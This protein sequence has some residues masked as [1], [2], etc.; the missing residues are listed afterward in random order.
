MS[1]SAR[2]RLWYLLPP[3]ACMAVFWRVPF[4]WFQG[5]DFAWLGLWQRADS[6]AGLTEALFRPYAQGTVR[7]FSERL[8]FLVLGGVFGTWA[9]PFRA[10][11]LG[12]WFLSLLLIQAIGARL[13]GSRAAGV[14][15]ALLWTVSAPLAEPLDWASAYNQ[16][17]CALLVLLAFYSRLR[18]KESGETK[19]RWREAAAYLAGFGALEIVVMYPVVALLEAAASRPAESRPQAEAPYPA[20]RSTLWMFL[21]A[22]LFTVAHLLWIP[23]AP[24]PAYQLAIDGRLP[25]TLLQYIA[26]TVGPGSASSL[27]GLDAVRAAITWT[28]GGS[29]AA[30]LAWRLLRGDRA[31]LLCA[32]WFLLFLAPVL[33]LPNHVSA[34]YLTVPGIGL[35]WLAGWA[36]VSAAR[37]QPGP[38]RAWFAAA[39]LIAGGYVAG[40]IRAV[41][42]ITALHLRASSRMRILVRAVEQTA[43]THPESRTVVLR[44]VDAELYKTGFEDDPFRL[45]GFRQTYLAPD[46]NQELSGLPLAPRLRATPERLL[47]ML[48][49][50]EARVL[51]ISPDPVRDITGVYHKVLA[52]GFL[53]A[54][55]RE[56]DL[57]NPVYAPRLGPGWYG[58]EHGGRWSAKSAWVTLGGPASAAELLRVSGLAPPQVPLGLAVRA[59]G[60]RIGAATLVDAGKPFE[61]A[62]P[63]PR[64]LVGTYAVAVTLECS[65][66]FRAPGDARELGVLVY[67]FVV[68]RAD[69][70]AVR[71]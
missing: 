1:A 63:V 54:H 29:L 28:G 40:S 14:L 68:G 42:F 59:N 4:V 17:L 2:A 9:A 70:P 3:L 24:A 48:E 71:R 12:T 52:A 46:G 57:G 44:G 49:G 58:I 60:R 45:A 36:L 32:G 34:Y 55:R 18:W 37:I 23:K 11:A 6:P 56:V 15:A 67:R 51:E 7:V 27:V 50:R 61:L 69:S 33:P 39:L 10:A 47:A 53:A 38:G 20:W 66:S 62:F 22:G 25:L 65:R 5:D 35:A 43:A 26:W 16:L 8:Y 13:A 31:A 19:W 30:F 41:D 64:D 21:P